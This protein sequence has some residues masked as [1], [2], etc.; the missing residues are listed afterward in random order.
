MDWTA[1][2]V[3]LRLAFWT[4]VILLILGT[5]LAYWLTFGRGRGRFLVEA[6]VALPLVLPPTVLGF[7]I[8]MATGP[9]S[10][11]G[12]LYEALTGRLL[13]FSFQGLLVASVLYSLPFAVQPLV[14]AFRGIDRRLLEAAWCL[15]S[16]PLTTFFRVVVPLAAPGFWTAI[17]LSF[18]HT[19]GEFGVV[20]MV[21]G[22]LPGVTRTVS[23]AIYD[24]VQALNYAAAGQTALALLVFS[25]VVL[26]AVYSLRRDVWALWPMKS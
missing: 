14:T 9:K 11:I 16:G 17:V 6:V 21:G 22:N 7:Y 10:P 8:L 4:T 5:P 20:L 25:F 13:P 1:I 24:E 23:I 18:A 12:R 2:G 19:V 15:G 3:S 26:V